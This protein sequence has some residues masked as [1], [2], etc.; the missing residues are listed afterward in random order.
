[1]PNVFEFLGLP[2]DHRPINKVVQLVKHYDEVPDSRK[3]FPLIGQ[4][5]CDGVFAMQVS[6]QGRHAIF[7]RTG[8]QLTNVSHVIRDYVPDGVY[9]AELTCNLMSLEQ[10]SGCVNPNRVEPLSEDMACKSNGFRMEYHDFITIRGFVDGMWGEP[11]TCRRRGLIDRLGGEFE[12]LDYTVILCEDQLQAFADKCITAGEEGAVFKQD[13][14]WE[15]GHKGWRSMKIVRGVSYDLECT[16][17]E[18]GTGKYAGKV[19]N[20]LFRWKGGKTIKA[21]L[22]KGWTHDAAEDLFYSAEAGISTPVGKIFKV[23]AL[24]ESSKGVLRLPKVREQRHDKQS[25]DY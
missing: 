23:V 18:E 12:V 16:G 13:T 15:A 17:Y 10:L 11:Y 21:M 20:L 14:G 22:G 24:Q 19:A 3:S 25:A 4:V 9:I 7:G 8:L 6:Y 1:M 2:K 5:K